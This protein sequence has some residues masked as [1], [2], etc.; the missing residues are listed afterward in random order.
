MSS[1]EL[2]KKTYSDPYSKSTAEIRKK[3]DGL[4]L[5]VLRSKRKVDKYMEKLNEKQVE[6]INSINVK[7]VKE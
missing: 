4:F 5:S 3:L 7:N 1:F 2:G 6:I